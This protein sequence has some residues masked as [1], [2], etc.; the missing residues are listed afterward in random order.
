MPNTRLP[1]LVPL[2]ALCAGLSAEGA[3]A[4]APALTPEQQQAWEELKASDGHNASRE[5]GR[6]TSELQSL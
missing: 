3:P 6:D 1:A 5:I 4:P 2:L